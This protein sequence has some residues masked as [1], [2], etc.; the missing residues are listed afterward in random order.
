VMSPG[1]PCYARNRLCSLT[2]CTFS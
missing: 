1:I 2:H